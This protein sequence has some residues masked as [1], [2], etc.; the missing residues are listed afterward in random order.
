MLLSLL[1]RKVLLLLLPKP[2]TL[3]S[4]GVKARFQQRGEGQN[5][6]SKL[7]CC[8]GNPQNKTIKRKES[9]SFLASHSHW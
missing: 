9:F 2:K 4:P 3:W 7:A 1:L 8:Q 5:L 6:L